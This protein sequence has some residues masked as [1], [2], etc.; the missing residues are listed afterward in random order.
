MGGAATPPKQQHNAAMRGDHKLGVYKHPVP[1]YPPSSPPA[2][3]LSPSRQSFRAMH[4]HPK[5]INPTNRR[6]NEHRPPDLPQYIPWSPWN[7][8]NLRSELKDYRTYV[9]ILVLTPWYALM[10]LASFSSFKNDIYWQYW[11]AH[12]LMLLCVGSTFAVRMLVVLFRHE[13]DVEETDVECGGGKSEIGTRE[14]MNELRVGKRRGEN[15]EECGAVSES[16]KD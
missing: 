4:S 16:K 8:Q 3:I 5:L 7:R 9:M 6:P 15:S 1:R 2:I 11:C 12:S 13:D 14:R 10:L